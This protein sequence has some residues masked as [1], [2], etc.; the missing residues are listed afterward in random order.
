M[1]KSP[2]TERTIDETHPAAHC[3]VVFRILTRLD[4]DTDGVAAF[5]VFRFTP[6]HSAVRLFDCVY[7]T[8]GGRLA[9]PVHPTPGQQTGNT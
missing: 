6:V 9:A 8:G 3:K 2:E 4:S 5:S 7:D 1:K